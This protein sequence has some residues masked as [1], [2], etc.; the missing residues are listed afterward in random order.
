MYLYLLFFFFVIVFLVSYTFFEKDI[1]S[2]SVILAI[3]YIFSVFWAI[4]AQ[5]LWDVN[6]GI[7]A[8]F[9]LILGYLSFFFVEVLMRSLWKKGHA[10]RVIENHIIGR[11]YI[12]VQKGVYIL[13]IIFSVI[14][15]FL[16]Y[17]EVYRIASSHGYNGLGSFLTIYRQS[18]SYGILSADEEINVFINQSYKIV[19]A[20]AYI[21]LY[22]F[23]N[24]YIITK[25]WS[26]LFWCRFPVYLYFVSSVFTG[27]RLQYIR[28][29]VSAFVVLYLL[30]NYHIQW[31]YK[32]SG[33]M[34]RYGVIGTTVLLVAFYAMRMIVG[35][36][37]GFGEGIIYYIAHYA[38]SSI[39]VF[40]QYVKHPISHG[41]YFGEET[42]Y[43]IYTALR[44]LGLSD[45]HKIAHLEFRGV[46]RSTSNTYTAIRRYYHD[47]GI[48]GVVVFQGICSWFYSYFYYFKCRS[49]N[50]K[51][52][53]IILY[54]F[55]LFP[56]ALHSINEQFF[57]A[58]ISVAYAMYVIEIIVLWKILY[59]VR[60]TFSNRTR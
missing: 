27:S 7:N 17:K 26:S 32:I 6:I 16:Y 44:K 40:D 38:G 42:F 48:I 28:F 43:G 12:V 39:C 8:F 50:C 11:E 25:K 3:T 20:G 31:N 51:P 2:P 29:V 33:K 37:E 53:T 18:A 14:I 34:I 47:F 23:I 22:I 59:N 57:S 60:F 49:R 45:Y 4:Y 24:N 10:T 52:I 9:L 36:G 46:G 58:I 19:A 5:N 13:Y 35:R 1:L 55:L 56:I 15:T 41:K 21:F 30:W 54:A